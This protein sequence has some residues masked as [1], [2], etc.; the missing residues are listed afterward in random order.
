MQILQQEIF[1][2]KQQLHYNK[3]L[4]KILI[5]ISLM[6]SVSTIAMWFSKNSGNIEIV[7]LGWQIS[8]SLSIFLLTIFIFFFFLILFLFLKK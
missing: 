8:T 6:A 3:K 4:I 2:Q 7:W 1:L 5:F